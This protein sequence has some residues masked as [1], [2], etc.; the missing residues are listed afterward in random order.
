MWQTFQKNESQH[1]L[2]L[3]VVAGC[4][5][6]SL[7]QPLILLVAAVVLLNEDGCPPALLESLLLVVRPE[8]GLD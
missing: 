2:D 5:S 3:G 8:L 7:F 1:L 4:S 6:R